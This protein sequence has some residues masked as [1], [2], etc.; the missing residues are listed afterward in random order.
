MQLQ[1]SALVFEHILSYLL[2]T[3]TVRLLSAP[4]LSTLVS[5]NNDKLLSPLALFLIITKND[6]LNQNTLTPPTTTATSFSPQTPRLVWLAE[7]SN[8]NDLT[9]AFQR[10]SIRRSLLVSSSIFTDSPLNHRTSSLQ[11]KDYR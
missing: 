4:L 6:H 5:P 3:T 8:K 9:I 1:C 10:N 7:V 11:Q 2:P